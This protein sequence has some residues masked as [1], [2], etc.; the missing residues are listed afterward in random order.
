MSKDLDTL[1]KRCAKALKDYVKKCG[2][3]PDTNS[4]FL[5]LVDLIQ[6]WVNME[7]KRKLKELKISSRV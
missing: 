5:K 3:I 1:Q 7:V 6:E 4:A 2:G